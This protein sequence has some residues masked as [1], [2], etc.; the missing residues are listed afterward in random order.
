MHRPRLVAFLVSLCTLA[1][2]AQ[3]G[4]QSKGFLAP[5]AEA[6]IGAMSAVRVDRAHDVTY[7]ALHRGKVPLLR[8]GADGKYLGGWGEGLFK[9]PHGLR[10]GPDGNVWITDNGLHTVQKFAPEGKLPSTLKEAHGPLKSPDDIVF[11]PSW[12]D[13]LYRGY[14]KCADFAVK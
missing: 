3:A 14:R 12:E 4:F 6:E 7:H 1:A 8:F 13:V 10:I 2:T 9:V 5:P 11:S